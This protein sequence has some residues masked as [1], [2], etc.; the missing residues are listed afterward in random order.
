MSYTPPS[1]PHIHN[2]RVWRPAIMPETSYYTLREILYAN[3]GYDAGLR[4][5]PFGCLGATLL[6]E[7][8]ILSLEERSPKLSGISQKSLQ[9]RLLG[10]LPAT[11]KIPQ[12]VPITDLAQFQIGDTVH[13]AARIDAPIV[14]LE[15]KMLLGALSSISGKGP[16]FTHDCMHVTL[17]KFR[18]GFEDRLSNAVDAISSLLGPTLTLNPVE[19]VSVPHHIRR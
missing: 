18:H 13:L 7:S 17:A 6:K 1:R 15:R 9:T 19:T 4:P 8:T 10:K 11:S 2:T 3:I 16:V 14:D 12:K 5:R